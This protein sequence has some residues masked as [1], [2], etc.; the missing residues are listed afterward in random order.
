MELAGSSPASVNHLRG[1]LRTVFAKA[2]KAGLFGG[3]NPVVDTELRKVPK[4]IAPTLSAQHVSVVL[5]EVPR[6]TT[7][8]GHAD[9]IPVAPA[10]LPHLAAAIDAS[11]SELVFPASD[12]TMH[13]AERGYEHRARAGCKA[14]GM[15]H[16]ERQADANLRHCP[17]CHMKLWPRPLKSKMRFRWQQSSKRRRSQIGCGRR[18]E[19]RPRPTTK[20]PFG[21]PVVR[22]FR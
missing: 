9:V 21:A 8:G 13:H 5:G 17:R 16:V 11:P 1:K 7:K 20:R 22:H 18:S 19:T 4:R 10:L 3:H 2:R 14:K 15:S 6:D 12:G